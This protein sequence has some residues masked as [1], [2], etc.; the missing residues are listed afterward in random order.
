MSDTASDVI[1]LVT[2]AVNG[3]VPDAARME[4][5]DLDAAFSFASEHMIAVAVGCAL[6]N[7]GVKDGRFLDAVSAS[8]RKTMIFDSAWSGI[9]KRLEDAEIWYMPLKGA[10]L[11][12]M[13]PVYGMREFADFDILFDA[14]RENDVK[15][16]MEALGFE[17]VEFGV[18]NHDVYYKAPVLNFEMHTALFSAAHGEKK[19]A[20]YKDIGDRLVREEGW[21]RSF[22]P[23]DF[24]LYFLAH[25]HGHYEG[26]G[27]GLRS[28]LDT[29]VY[30]NRVRLD[31]D[32]VA[33]EAEKL[34]LGSFEEQN[35]TL[36]LRL[37]GGETLSD[38][39]REML[40]YFL[41]S[42]AFG[43][44]PNR[45]R[46][47]MRRNGGNRLRYLAG[48]IRVPFSRKDPE[49]AAFAEEYPLFYR[50]RILLPFLPFYRVIRAVRLGRFQ[51]EAKTLRDTRSRKE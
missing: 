19:L 42:G 35:R 49:Y 3:T 6:E 47:T 27:T 12:D 31:M 30:L 21:G 51:E 39:D 5:M 7:A 20:Y 33:A 46:N 43:T 14:A 37:F 41:S 11:K 15:A 1:Y 44:I 10:V 28:L 9:R 38:S 48:R 16:I 50:Y 8:I 22:T 18:H 13:Y 29:Y 40:D 36:A 2:C 32:Y 24:Y 23:E 17:T 25:E 34:G 26:G 45:V 4:G